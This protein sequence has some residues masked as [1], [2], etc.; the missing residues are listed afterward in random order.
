MYNNNFLSKV[1]MYLFIGLLVTFAT[2]YLVS[3]NE[4]LLIQ[5]YVNNIYWIL[6]ILEIGIA[7]FLSARI[8]KLKPLT[9]TLLYFFY[10]ILTGATLS[11]IFIAYSIGSIIWIFLA[12]AI[13]FGIFSIIG[14][15]TKID[16]RGI[17][18]FLIMGLIAVIILEIINMFI[19]NSTLDI[20]TCV[21]GLIIF[22]AYIAYDVQI[23]CRMGNSS[24][25][26][27]E[28][29]A[30]IGAFSLYLDFINVFIRLLRLFGNRNN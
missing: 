4:N 3:T 29:L 22:M 25:V 10:A 9:A 28:N 30:I 18:T 19:L 2:S 17:G 16:L 20:I 23:V 11:S 14:K 26:P 27:L 7:L 6:A 15:N 24:N 8:Y 1:F 13:V 12:S 5:I 21:I